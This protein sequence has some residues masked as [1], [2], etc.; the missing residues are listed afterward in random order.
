M[1]PVSAQG[2]PAL[3][4]AMAPVAPLVRADRPEEIAFAEG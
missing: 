1:V 4:R 3:L 2:G